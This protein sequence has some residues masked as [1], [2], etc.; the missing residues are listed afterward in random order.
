MM[1]KEYSIG[2]YQIILPYDHLLDRDQSTWLRYDTALGYIAGSVFQK[3][4]ESSAID[5]GAN[6][7]DSAALIKKYV[8]IPVLCIEGNPQFIEYLK[9]NALRIGGIEIAEYFVGK[10]GDSVNLDRLLSCGGT[11]SIIDAIDVEDAA[12]GTKTKSLASIISNYPQFQNS[13]LLKIDTDGFD[14]FIIKS[15]IDLISQ[16]SPVLYFEYDITFEANGESAGLETIQSL[17]EIG[18]EYFIVYDNYGN[19]LISL[20]NDEYDRFLDLTTY[21]ASNRKRSGTPV[22]YYFDICAFTEKD[23]DLFEEIRLGEINLSF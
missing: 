7:G 14:F 15:S 19:Y 8:D 5:I 11:A 13:Q 22:V 1:P 17:F 3:Y 9:Q 21:L 12:G 18:Y 16:L 20:S 10:E 6:V 23:L 2:P 4:P